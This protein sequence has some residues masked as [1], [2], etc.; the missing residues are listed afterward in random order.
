MNLEAPPWIADF[1]FSAALVF[2]LDVFLDFS[3][4]V[5]L[6]LDV[7]G[8]FGLGLFCYSRCVLG[9]F[10]FSWDWVWMVLRTLS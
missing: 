8:V 6:L 9:L 1:R 5:F 10:A 4:V 3:G 7:F 2:F